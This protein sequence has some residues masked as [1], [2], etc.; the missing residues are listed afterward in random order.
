LSNDELL[1]ILANATDIRSVEKHINKCFD[2][3][4]GLIL[5]EQGGGSN[6]ITG[7]RS[8]EGEQVEIA[9]I[10]VAPNMGVEIWMKNLE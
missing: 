6:L 7:M 3:I 1:Q 8:G 10:K 9:R 5:T 4:C 2:N